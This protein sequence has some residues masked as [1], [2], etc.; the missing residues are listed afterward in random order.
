MRG[1]GYQQAQAVL[2]AVGLLYDPGA[3]AIRVE[4]LDDIVDLEI[5]D[6]REEVLAAE[7]YKVR[8]DAYTWGQEELLAVLRRWAALPAAPT[9]EF[10]FVTDGRLGPTG[11]RVRDALARAA[12]GDGEELAALI[13]EPE[14]SQVLRGLSRASVRRDPV[15]VGALLLR[16]ERQVMAL[17]P[18]VMSAETPAKMRK[19]RSTVC[20]PCSWSA[21][22]T[23]SPRNG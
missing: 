11:E 3:I 20:L 5:F 6:A 12:N 10:E 1:I 2:E 4:G 15:G 13:G 8:A 19:R 17:L 22:P 18:S 7:Q 23:R 9:A 21:P 16:A 14:D